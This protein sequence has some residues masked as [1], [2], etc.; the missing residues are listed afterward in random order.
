MRNAECG[1]RNLECGMR[2]VEYAHRLALL[3]VIVASALGKKI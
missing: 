1:M 2:S 3:L